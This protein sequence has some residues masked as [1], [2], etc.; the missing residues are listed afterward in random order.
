MTRFSIRLKSH[1]YVCLLL[2]CMP[3]RTV[4]CTL[5]G[6]RV[7][8]TEIFIHR[9]SECYA[10]WKKP[11]APD[12]TRVAFVGYSPPVPD[13]PSRVK[14]LYRDPDSRLADTA[15]RWRDI[16]L[17]AFSSRL[18]LENKYPALGNYFSRRDVGMTKR[19]F[20]QAIHDSAFEWVDCVEFPIVTPRVRRLLNDHEYVEAFGRRLGS[21][22]YQLAV[23]VS[24]QQAAV[25]RIFREVMIRIGMKPK[26]IVLP[27][28]LW[29]MSPVVA[30]DL[31][32]KAL[33]DI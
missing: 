32:G 16:L 17:F 12:N 31:I 26:S 9:C 29:Y 14:Y 5:C 7:A 21:E 33:E 4:R 13:S 1:Q 8:K 15:L 28:N 2:H 18:S 27:G 25:E 30:G 22:G 10:A 6:A 23:F 24:N 20:L 11:F 19:P 3:V